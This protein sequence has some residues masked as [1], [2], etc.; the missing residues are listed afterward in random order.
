MFY[1]T[2]R[3]HSGICDLPPIRFLVVWTHGLSGHDWKHGRLVFSLKIR[4]NLVTQM[5][6]EVIFSPV[7][8]T[9]TPLPE[10]MSRTK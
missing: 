8:E 4:P 10:R 1:N 3:F 6:E 9:T 5:L 7:Q 2:E